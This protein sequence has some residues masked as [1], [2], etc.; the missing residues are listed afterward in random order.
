M[1]DI[2]IL[3]HIKTVRATAPV[4]L[5]TAVIH[6]EAYEGVVVFPVALYQIAYCG[7]GS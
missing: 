2:K 3:F 4:Y 7:K 5:V 6:S 1:N